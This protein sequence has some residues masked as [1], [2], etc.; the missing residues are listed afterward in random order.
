LKVMSPQVSS[1]RPAGTPLGGVAQ[2]LRAFVLDVAALVAGQH[3]RLERDAV[4]GGAGLDALRV[5][6]RAAAELQHHV[7]AEQVD[8]LVHLAGVDAAGRDRH[9]LAQRAQSCSK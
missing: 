3:H 6:D 1:A 4:G 8:Q 2:D 5:A 9:H 7:V